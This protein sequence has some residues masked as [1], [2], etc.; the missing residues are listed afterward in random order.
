MRDIDKTKKRPLKD[1][2]IREIKS[3]LLT[4]VEQ[5]ELYKVIDKCKEIIEK[6]GL[7]RNDQSFKEM[8]K[9]LLIKMNEERRVKRRRRTK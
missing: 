4:L 5:K 9:I 7:I 6:K 8:T 3:V 2:E 1:V